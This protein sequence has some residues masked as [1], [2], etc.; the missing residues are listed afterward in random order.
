VHH[1]VKRVAVP[2]QLLAVPPGRYPD[3]RQRNLAATGRAGQRR[4]LIGS[5]PCSISSVLMI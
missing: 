4:L 5:K 1:P 2:Q 3:L